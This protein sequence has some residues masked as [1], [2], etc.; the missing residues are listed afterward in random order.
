MF[1]SADPVFGEFPGHSSSDMWRSEHSPA[2]PTPSVRSAAPVMQSRSPLGPG[3]PL[4]RIRRLSIDEQVAPTDDPFAVRRH[5]AYARPKD[6]SPLAWGNTMRRRSLGS[7][8]L[9][10]GDRLGAV[11]LAPVPLQGS[12][13]AGS[14][15]SPGV[16]SSQWPIQKTQQS[17]RMA[18]L[19][20]MDP[21]SI[22][23][24]SRGGSESSSELRGDIGR[25]IHGAPP[26]DVFAQAFSQ[27]LEM[28]DSA[29]ITNSPSAA[30]S[31]PASPVEYVDTEG[32]DSGSDQDSL[33]Q[34]KRGLPTDTDRSR[35]VLTSADLERL[36]RDYG[37]VPI[38]VSPTQIPD[39]ARTAATSRPGGS[40]SVTDTERV[41]LEPLD[42]GRIL[43]A[44]AE[45]APDA[46]LQ[47]DTASA[48]SRAR[49]LLRRMNASDGAARASRFR[50]TA[51][52][53]PF[54]ES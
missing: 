4:D 35:Q 27:T 26:A 13:E 25:P 46:F 2:S 20:Q 23:G 33:G 47:V 11:Q 24:R 10:S 50:G 42:L 52:V 21:H 16:S 43:V 28:R 7:F 40:K 49:A 48:V 14:S 39:I 32:E 44:I 9:S 12:P 36:L 41:V 5:G 17:S 22:S 3:S 8:K 30:V 19:R 54:Y 37:L 38:C 45:Q 15:T 34:P 53:P 18:L 1:D 29:T 6:P 31:E 51:I